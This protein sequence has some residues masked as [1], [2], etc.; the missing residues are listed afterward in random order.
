MFH[1]LRPPRPG[2]NGLGQSSLY[3]LFQ[4]DVFAQVLHQGVQGRHAALTLDLHPLGPPVD[5][6]AAQN[7]VHDGEVEVPHIGG[8]ALFLVVG[9][10]GR[11]VVQTQDEVVA[12]QVGFKLA[13]PLCV[14][15]IP[16]HLGGASDYLLLLFPGWQHAVSMQKGA[17]A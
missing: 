16:E 15:F 3:R 4:F 13:A 6:E 8:P 17:P 9:N 5:D 12:L 14:Q 11:G 7:L 10:L 1:A 2:G